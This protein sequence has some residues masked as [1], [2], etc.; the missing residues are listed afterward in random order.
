MSRR[1]STGVL[2]HFKGI[3]RMHGNTGEPTAAMKRNGIRIDRKENQS[4]L[5]R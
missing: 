3:I 5:N 4:R 2:E 1:D